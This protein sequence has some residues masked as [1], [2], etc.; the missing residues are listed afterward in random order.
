M[1]RSRIKNKN[2][3]KWILVVTLIIAMCVAL[4]KNVV[5][6]K[7]NSIERSDDV[8]KSISIYQRHNNIDIKSQS[9]IMLDLKTKDILF[10]KKSDKKMFPASTTKALT[11]ITVLDYL[12]L[13]EVLRVGDEANKI[14]Y[15]ASRAGL[16]YGEKITVKDL[17]Y[18]LMLPSGNDAAYVLAVNTARK[19]YQDDKMSIELAIK[20]FRNLMNQKAKSL[21]VKQSNFI[22]VDGYHNDNHYTTASDLA[23][24]ASNA[25][26]N[27]F[28]KDVVKT[29]NFKIKDYKQYNKNDPKYRSWINTNMLIQKDSRWYMKEVTGFKTGHTNES[30]YSLII[31]AHIDNKDVLVVLLGSTKNEIYRD[32]HKLL[33]S[34]KK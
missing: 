3:S 25:I 26:E 14:A 30:G 22:T 18:G 12:K 21:G 5:T 6:D 28:L 15:N 31:T 4:H 20:K 17:I 29:T 34:I 23:L 27:D 10:A 13:D 9:A 7:E 2:Y 1:R 11:A 33:L 32:A 24:I 8:E 19:A 16:D